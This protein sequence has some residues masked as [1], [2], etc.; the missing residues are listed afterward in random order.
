LTEA[1]L[2]EEE[3]RTAQLSLLRQWAQSVETN[4][5]FADYY[6]ESLPVYDYHGRFVNDE[7]QLAILTPQALHRAARRLFTPENV[8]Y[9]RDGDRQAVINAD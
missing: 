7:I 5:G 1:P 8:V 9:V 2:P 3:F 4:E 6:I